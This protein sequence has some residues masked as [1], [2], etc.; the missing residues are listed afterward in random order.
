[1]KKI[2]LGQTITIVANLGVIAGIILLA[3]ELQQNNDLLEAQ[4]RASRAQVRIDA[5]DIGASNSDLVRTGIKE[6]NGE[7]LTEYDRAILQSAARAMLTRWQ[8]AYGEWQAGLLGDDDVPVEDW[9]R[10]FNGGLS[11]QQVWQEQGSFQGDFVRWM[12]EN[13]VSSE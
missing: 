5:Y 10:A 11:A 9:K 13:V 7:T 6:Q 3:F 2:D 4:A 8:Y 12:N 1:M